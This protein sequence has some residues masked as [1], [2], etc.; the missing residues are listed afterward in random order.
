MKKITSI[1][2]LYSLIIIGATQKLQAQCSTG[3][4][5][6]IVNI[7]PD[8]Y[9]NETSWDIRDTANI[10]IASGTITSDTFCYAT[11]ILL[12]FTIYDS[13]GD[14][15]CCGG[16]G[17]GAYYVYLDDNLVATGGHF[18]FSE[19]T[20]FNYPSGAL[21]SILVNNFQQL[22]NHCNGTTPLS[23]AQINSVATSINQN[24]LYIA[25]NL[26]VITAAFNLINCYETSPGP[27]FMN[28]ATTGGFPNAPVGALD[29]FEYDR[30]IFLVQQELFNVLYTKN[31]IAQYHNFLQD[32]KYLTS[33]YF[34]GACPLPVD[35]SH[36]YTATVNASMPTTWGKP[37][38][39]ATTPV[40]RPT[41]YYLSPGSIGKVKVPNAMV[42]AGYK[43]LVGALP[44][45]DRTVHP[46]V[47]R[48]FGIANTYNITDSVTLIANPFGGG[49]YIITPYQASAGLQQVELTNVVPAP[50][51]SATSFNQTTL[52]DWRNV[53]RLNPAPWADFESDKFMMQVPTSFIYNY[54]DPITLMA[55]WDAR[56][57]VVSNF[58]GYPL[59]RNNKV[60]YVMLDVQILHGAYGIGDPQINN[61]YNPN[62]PQNG[63]SQMW[64]LV[65]GQ[66]HMWESE[67]HELGHAQLMVKFP[68]EE[69]AMVNI[70]SA[71]IYNQLYGMTIDSAFGMSFNNQYWRGR[72]QSAINWMITHNFRVGNPMDISNTTKD[73]VRYQHRGYGKYIEIAALFGWSALENYNHQVSL[74][75]INGV[76]A[77]PLGQ[78]D[79]RILKLSI[80]ANADLRP[81]IHF[82]GVQPQDSA[83]LAQA[84]DSNNLQPSPLICNR[85]THYLSIIPM[86][87]TQF[88][89]QAQVY[90]NGPVPPGGDP[91]YE[92][93]W[94]NVWLPLYNHLH[95][96]SAVVALQKIINTYFPGGCATVNVPALPEI[97]NG[98]SVSV[99]PNPNT[100]EFTISQNNTNKTEIEIY[101]LVGER[102]YK[103]EFTNLTTTIDLSQQPKGIYFL[104]TEDHN[105]NVIIKKV[106]IQ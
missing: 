103:T 32:R 11:G 29:G 47:Q 102:I 25:E 5:Q 27:L 71:A 10:V 105:R 59:V 21:S 76:P 63:N 40:R 12:H 28:T 84:I 38:A 51:F 101:N 4:S 50:Y 6:I 74:D 48:L 39:W 97:S 92:E 42:N 30:A 20:T 53:Q 14:G 67:F 43:I 106:I 19:T 37:S 49:I 91:D 64:F 79:D 54:S 80:A 46:T 24:Q 65:P 98:N 57:D 87:S 82:W 99:F 100:G 2:I 61:P 78:V 15:I 31:K 9:P 60:L 17:D 72:D 58:M 8:T 16:F 7:T 90:F 35:S 66:A 18:G 89:L 88:R 1:L 56:M 95:A 55:D 22:L 69:E 83:A 104:K 75:Y 3:Y 94:Y 45:M 34:P 70:L 93:G 36:V 44:L 23:P 73:E 86:D 85:L 81:L 68:G 77:G 26:E 62:D 96:D 52:S 41:G 13:Y 33:N